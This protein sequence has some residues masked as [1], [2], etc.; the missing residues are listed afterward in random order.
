[1]NAFLFLVYQKNVEGMFRLNFANYGLFFYCL[2]LIMVASVGSTIKITNNY[3]IFHYLNQK[4]SL[5]TS[6]FCLH[7]LNI[8]LHRKISCGVL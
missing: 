6:N 7:R 8:N 4:P 1:M 3:R 5:E 2:S